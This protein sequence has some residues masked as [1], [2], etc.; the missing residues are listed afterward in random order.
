VIIGLLQSPAQ[1]FEQ[2]RRVV[3]GCTQGG[4]A[5][6]PLGR[7]KYLGEGAQQPLEHPLEAV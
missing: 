3:E 6:V 1:T 2:R 4:Q 5:F 7:I